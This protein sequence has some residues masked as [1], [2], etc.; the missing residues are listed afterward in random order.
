MDDD[1]LQHDSLSVH[2]LA[3]LQPIS[4]H[5]RTDG[6][7]PHARLTCVSQFSQQVGIEKNVFRSS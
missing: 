4:A 5:E 2:L 3:H 1:V 6:V 7:R